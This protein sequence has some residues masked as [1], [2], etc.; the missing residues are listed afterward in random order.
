MGV[1]NVQELVGLY[2]AVRQKE[3]EKHGVRD[4]HETVGR[5]AVVKLIN[6]TKLLKM[7]QS[8]EMIIYNDHERA[9]VVGAEEV[10]L[11][12]AIVAVTHS[13]DDVAAQVQPFITERDEHHE[14]QNRLSL[15]RQN[16]EELLARKQSDQDAVLEE[17]ELATMMLEVEEHKAKEEEKIEIQKVLQAQIEIILAVVPDLEARKAELLLEHDQ[18]VKECESVADQANEDLRWSQALSHLHLQVTVIYEG[19]QAEHDL[20]EQD[21]SRL[22][23]EIEDLEMKA[24]DHE[25]LITEAGEAIQDIMHRVDDIHVAETKLQEEAHHFVSR[26]ARMI[27]ERNEVQKVQ[28]SRATRGATQQAS[29]GR[30]ESSRQQMKDLSA[31]TCSGSWTQSSTQMAS[32]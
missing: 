5:S 30:L 22:E 15:E 7:N 20:A 19:L 2:K 26:K 3:Q 29:S 28:A 9:K 12:A 17:A 10:K 1:Q 23:R 4:H 31:Q 13:L 18:K 25:H 24:K 16:I 21:L 32:R 11:S 6:A 27:A 14:T 8:T